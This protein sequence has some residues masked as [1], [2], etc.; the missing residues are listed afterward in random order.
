MIISEP[1][2]TEVIPTI[3]LPTIPIATV[4]ARCTS[5]SLTTPVRGTA[6]RRSSA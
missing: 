3:S 1:D 6:P 5:M 2:P 4:R